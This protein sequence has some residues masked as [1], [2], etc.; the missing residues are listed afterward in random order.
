M[1]ESI[2]T[3]PSPPSPVEVFSN[4]WEEEGAV[5]FET[6]KPSLRE[7]RS[8]LAFRPRKVLE[9]KKALS[10]SQFFKD[11]E[12]A[13][14][15]FFCLGFLGYDL[16]LLVEDLPDG[17]PSDIDLPDAWIGAYD[18][19]LLYDH[20]EK[21][22][23]VK[24]ASNENISLPK[25]ALSPRDRDPGFPPVPISVL[26]VPN[27]PR[28]YY[29]EAVRKAQGYIAK[30]DIY[31]LNF[32]QRF[33]FQWQFSPWGLYLRLR[34][35]QPVPYGA[36]LNLGGRRF[37]ISGSPELF[38]RVKNGIIVSKPMKGTI[39][40]GKNP[41]EDESLR[42][43]LRRSEKDRAEN[44]MIVDLMRNDLGK[45]AKAGSV[46]VPKLFS[47]EGYRT[48]Y[49]M[50]SEVQGILKEGVGLADILTGL[51][52]PGSV[53]GAP[54]KK[55]C[56]I[57]EELEPHRRGVYTGAIG[58]VEPSGEMAF[59]VAIRTLALSGDKGVMGVGGAIVADSDPEREYEESLLKARAAFRALGVNSERRE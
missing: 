4:H 30:G 48:V 28:D 29:F 5:L 26:P 1:R 53:T 42:R 41:A 36:F 6:Q 22:W 12:E 11:L 55:A 40:R 3:I 24:A 19:V 8:I 56:E 23:K 45:V 59:S 34:E 43:E 17:N 31:Q 25:E 35:A 50:V 54:K 7:R 46:G 57:I 49:Q 33:S 27:M 52:P 9:L 15:E 51:F 58:M 13:S 37:V 10:G 14:R 18:F 38:S 44:V 2:L 20:F 47:V 16:R 39:A 21:S 32:T